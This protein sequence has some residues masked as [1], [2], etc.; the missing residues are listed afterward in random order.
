MALPWHPAPRF[1]GGA[2]QI[3]L[4][5][6]AALGD[7]EYTVTVK[8]GVADLASNALAAPHTWRFTVGMADRRVY[9]PLV[10]RN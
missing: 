7:G 8:T 10:L 3:V 1:D 9:L 6:R 4:I 5:P 2:N